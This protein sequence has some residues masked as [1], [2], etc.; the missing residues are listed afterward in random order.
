MI[1]PASN[2]HVVAI[3][4]NT[5]TEFKTKNGSISGICYSFPYVFPPSNI[6]LNKNSKTFYHITSLNYI[7]KPKSQYSDNC[8]KLEII[9]YVFSTILTL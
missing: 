1:P 7:S 6:Y 2:I 9:H 5:L 8:C 3:P 4:R